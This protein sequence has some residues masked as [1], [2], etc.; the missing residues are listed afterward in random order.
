MNT[1]KAIS[2]ISAVFVCIFVLIFTAVPHF[3]AN[4]VEI[5]PD[6]DLCTLVTCT[7]YGVNS[8]RLLVRGQRIDNIIVSNVKV[9][10]DAMQI[11]PMI[12][13]PVVAIPILLFLLMMIVVKDIRMKLRGRKIRKLQK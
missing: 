2:R 6:K 1:V 11:E 9:T 10:A 8:H 3:S 13:A 5:E 7:P 4:A 12:V